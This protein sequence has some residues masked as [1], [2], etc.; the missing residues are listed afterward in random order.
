VG[1]RMLFNSDSAVTELLRG[2]ESSIGMA[3]HYGLGGHG[4]ESRSGQDFPHPSRSALGPTQRP[5]QW[6]PGFSRGRAAGAWS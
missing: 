4:I 3:I 5:T 6:I 1:L 2:P